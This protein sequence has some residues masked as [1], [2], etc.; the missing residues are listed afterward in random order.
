MLRQ[1]GTSDLKQLSGHA[2][3][4]HCTLHVVNLVAKAHTL[5]YLDFELLT[6]AQSQAIMHSIR[7]KPN[8]VQVADTDNSTNSDFSDDDMLQDFSFFVVCMH[9]HCL[10]CQSPMQRRYKSKT[11]RQ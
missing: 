3:G 5:P 2:S 10:M 9:F 6:Y 7:T 4:V 1:L 8:R 11:L